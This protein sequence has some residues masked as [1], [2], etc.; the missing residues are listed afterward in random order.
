M[1]TLGTQALPTYLLQ[2][3]PF[4]F[5]CIVDILNHI[6][7]NMKRQIM[8]HNSFIVHL[9]HCMVKEKPAYHI[10]LRIHLSSLSLYFSDPTYHIPILTY[11]KYYLYIPSEASIASELNRPY[12]I[13]SQQASSTQLLHPSKLNTL[14]ALRPSTRPSSHRLS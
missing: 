5:S 2:A 9:K 12:C 11:E 7:L 1:D 10:N 6:M 3:M 13:I 8:N 14:I 4:I